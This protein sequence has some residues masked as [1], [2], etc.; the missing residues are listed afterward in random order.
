MKTASL[1]LIVA[2]LSSLLSADS[3]QQTGKP[4]W[5]AF[6]PPPKPPIPI[7]EKRTTKNENPIDAFLLAKLRENG[8]DFAPKADHR[9]LIR[10]I[11]CDLTGLP[12]DPEQLDEP[13]E[14]AVERLLAS[15]QYGE[16]WGRHWLDVV[17]FGETD[18][19]EHNYERLN[20][21]PYR[22]YVINSLNRDVPYDQF[23]REQIAGDLLFPNDRNKMAATG[24]LVAGPWDEVSANLN[25]DATMR[26]IA[27]MDELD[28][29]VT[30]I[31]ATFLGLTVN[32]ARCHDHK[33]DPIPARDYYRM[34]AAL[35][36][37][38]FGE[39]SVATAEEKAAYEQRVKPL[40]SELSPI[41]TE[42]TAIEESVAPPML[43]AKYKA[44]DEAR[45]AEKQRIPLNPLYNRNGFPPVTASRFRLVVMGQSSG[46]PRLAR[47]E[48]LPAGHLVRDWSAAESGSIDKPTYLNIDLPNPVTV[49]D[50]VWSTGSTASNRDGM[51]TIYRFEV[52]QDGTNWKSLCESTDHV[53]KLEVDL[54]GLSEEELSRALTLE[55]RNRRAELRKRRS[56]LQ[57][58]ISRIPLPPRLYAVNPR[59]PEKAFLLDRGSVLKQVEEV[60]PGG[61]S[62]ITTLSPDI[63]GMRDTEYGI[64]PVLAAAGQIQNPSSKIQN[65]P[66]IALAD[67]IA[68]PRNPLT[69]RVIV[70]RV[71]YYH[72]GAGIVNT[73]SDFGV[74]GDRPSHPELLDWLATSFIEHGWSLKWLHRQILS[75][76][77]YQ[78]SSRF[79]SRAHAIDAG[80]RLVWRMPLKRMDAETLRDSI[81]RVSG[82]LD[83]KAGG[84]SY[85]LQKKGDRG[86]YIYKALDNDGPE[87]WRRAVYRFVVRG[88]ERIMLD[89]LD[90]PD[91][92]VATPQRQ[93]SNTPVQALTLLNN[94]FVIRQS[95][96][97]ATRLE[98]EA[99]NDVTAQVNRAYSL[100]FGRN[101]T[102]GE[103]VR[104]RRYISKHSLPL[105]C[106]AMLNSNEFVYVP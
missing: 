51:I 46:K 91:P 71:W 49:S 99:P 26:K 72:F 10:R 15:P 95:G 7:V 86:S 3:P 25:K 59:E 69:A 83:L 90:C 68:N 66:R 58:Q 56:E 88:G 60:K 44:F 32:C 22:D 74:M 38:G 36:G 100:A 54:P 61:L 14:E 101:P 8:L 42:L 75:S 20:A 31:S 70:N 79:N 29:M 45:R 35:T 37:A 12:P 27:R 93:V 47:L 39:R 76:R 97:L 102:S 104:A 78:Q 98:K 55:Q 41:E 48:L 21:W 92:S 89:S 53:S 82:N 18:G 52:S 34:T 62:C 96:L 103:V 77:A 5:W 105:F 17:R 106:R 13:Y 57:E 67:W 2:A 80:N 64:G 87:V 43:L 63:A 11:H 50:I 23:I 24:F 4:V 28:D 1:A 84:P 9:P 65:D 33:F 73:P 6:V 19:G 85:P 40:R 81:L 30:T 16:R 94:A